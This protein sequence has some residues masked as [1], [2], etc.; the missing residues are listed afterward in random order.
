[1]SAFPNVRLIEGDGN[2]LGPLDDESFDVVY[3]HIVF[4]QMPRAAVASY[5]R[6]VHRVLRPGGSFLFQVPEAMGGSPPDPPDTETFEMRFYEEALLRQSLEG[7]GYCWLGCRRFRIES[8]ALVYDH[9]RP[10][11][12]KPRA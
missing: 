11:A 2:T 10:H 12:L 3:S 7:L 6:E 4:Q 9:L 1:M 8:S 5:F